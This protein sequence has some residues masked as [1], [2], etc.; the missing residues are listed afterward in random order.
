MY[1]PN[2]KRYDAMPYHRCGRSG[3]LLPAISLGLW[4]NFGT[5]ADIDNCRAMLCGSFDMGITHFDI[6][7]NY[8]P[9]PGSA[10][11]TLGKILQSDLAPH[12]DELF[13]ST[14]AGY[15]MW[16]GPYGDWG[17]KKYLLASLDQSLQRMG[18]EYVDLFYH[19]RRDGETPLEETMNALAGIVKSGKALYVGIS[20]YNPADTKAAVEMLD[21]MG[22]HCLI[23]QMRYSMLDRAN[24]AVLD[25]LQQMGVGSIAFSPLA[26]GVLTGKYAAGIPADSRAAGSS[27]F[28][29][30]ERVKEL[31]VD[32]ATALEPIARRRGQSMAQLALAW[33]LRKQRG[34][35]SVIIGASRL[36]QIQENCKALQNTDFT[37]E[38]LAEIESILA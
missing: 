30:P 34:V 2:A 23:H 4:H 36:A 25:V 35:T 21:A 37:A 16:P 10:E 28:L 3:V 1:T 13:I 33:V 18:L 5:Q 22:V 15:T 29:T 38:E 19:H 8:G 14:K 11:E 31:G 17:S 7:N 27:V 6:A 32:K 20:N 24:E 12:R 9:L 26:Q